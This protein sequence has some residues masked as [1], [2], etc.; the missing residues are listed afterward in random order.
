MTMKTT[1]LLTQY[2]SRVD[3]RFSQI[4]EHVLGAKNLSPVYRLP[5]AC[6]VGKNHLPRT[7]DVVFT[8]PIFEGI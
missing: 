1:I 5:T 3:M 6:A 8:S 2:L 4:L 7:C